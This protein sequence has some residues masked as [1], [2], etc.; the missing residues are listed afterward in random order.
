MIWAVVIII[1][2]VVIIALGILAAAAVLLLYRSLA[3]KRD[4]SQ[5]ELLAW[6]EQESDFCI[7]DVRSPDEYDSGHIPGSI[8]IGHKE[9]SSHLHDLEPHKAKNVVVY[10]EIGVRARMAQNTLARAG[11]ANVY[12]L[13][14][15]MAAWRET[16]RPTDST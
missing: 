8:N 1:W 11:F 7:L 12:H 15:D 6:M 13:K 10:C 16:G 3:G 5:E 4:I 2:A 14:G 9:I